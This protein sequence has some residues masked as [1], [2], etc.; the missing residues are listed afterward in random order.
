MDSKYVSRKTI[1]EEAANGSCLQLLTVTQI[2]PPP[3]PQ[4]LGTDA[5]FW[6]VDHELCQDK[7]AHS[8]SPPP[9]SRQAAPGRGTAHHTHTLQTGLV[10]SSSPGA[11]Q[12]F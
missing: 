9:V 12:H 5:S 1:T 11:L 10:I 2:C 3:S 6:E 7:D 4:L 8:F